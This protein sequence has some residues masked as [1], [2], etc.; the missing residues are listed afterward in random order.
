[1]CHEKRIILQKER[2][3]NAKKIDC[4][5]LAEVLD[6]RKTLVEERL[7]GKTDLPL[8]ARQ[9]LV[10]PF[11]HHRCILGRWKMNPAL[12]EQFL[13]NLFFSFSLSQ[14][15]TSRQT[16]TWTDRE[17]RQKKLAVQLF[18]V[19]NIKCTTFQFRNPLSHNPRTIRFTDSLMEG[20]LIP[21]WAMVKLV[22]SSTSFSLT[23][24]T[25]ACC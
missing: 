14:I 19:I 10:L 18:A 20:V 23:I 12:Q 22:M 3:K 17:H 7:N 8:C 11:S 13:R 15:H 1:M 4:G 5:S 6:R 2:K 24:N 25:T 16:D 9:V 21:K